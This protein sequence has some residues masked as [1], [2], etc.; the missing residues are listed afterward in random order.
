M[1]FLTVWKANA[2]EDRYLEDDC[3]RAKLILIAVGFGERE[4]SKELFDQYF[5]S[6]FNQYLN[7]VLILHW[8]LNAERLECKF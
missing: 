8:N 1:G 3:G 2:E 4:G 5:G 6:N 7:N